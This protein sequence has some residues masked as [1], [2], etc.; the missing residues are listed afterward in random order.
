MPRVD[1]ALL[2]RL[3]GESRGARW[4]LAREA[5]WRI[6]TGEPP[7]PA[8]RITIADDGAWKVL[9]NAMSAEEAAAAI[10]SEG[11]SIFR[12]AFVR[13]RSVIV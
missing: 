11:P 9:F 13:A 2:D 10:V 7:A 3:Y 1:P 12:D 5:S 6:V 8:A 4:T